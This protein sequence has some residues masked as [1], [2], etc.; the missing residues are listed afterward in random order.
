MSA[1]TGI[2]RSSALTTPALLAAGGV[3]G[4]AAAVLLAWFMSTLITSSEMTLNETGRNQMLDFVRVK[5]SETVERKDRKP[6]RPK[7]EKAPDMPDTLRNSA[8]SNGEVLAVSAPTVSTDIAIGRGGFGLGSGEGDYLPIVKV[9]PIYPPRALARGIEGECLVTY[10]V[11]PA[12][13]T[14]NVVV[15]EEHCVDPMFH[16]PSVEAAKRFKYKPRVIDGQA[17]EV[18][19]VFNMFHFKRADRE[20]Q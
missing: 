20:G 5:R 19:G 12:G 11:T 10:D 4:I 8:D 18:R 1:T 9:A 15:L 16:R 2:R 6:E 7:M 14:R 17:V 3:T 13:T